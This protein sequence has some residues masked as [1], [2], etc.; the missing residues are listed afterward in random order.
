MSEKKRWYVTLCV[1]DT[2]EVEADSRDEAEAK[3]LEVFDV[4]AA[5]GPSV[6]D[7][8][9]IDEDNWEK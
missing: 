7:S 5:D 1:M 9:E 8:W 3:A 6:H 2:V 4:T